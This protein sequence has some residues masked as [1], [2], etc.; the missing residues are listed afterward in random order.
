ME[1]VPTEELVRYPL[2]LDII[3]QEEMLIKQSNRITKL[4][5]PTNS[6]IHHLPETFLFNPVKSSMKTSLINSLFLLGFNA[7]LVGAQ[8]AA[9]KAL[10]GSSPVIA[11]E[12][13]VKVEAQELVEVSHHN[14][15]NNYCV[16]YGR[17]CSRDSECCAGYCRAGY[18]CDVR[19]EEEEEVQDIE[20]IEEDNV[21]EENEELKDEAPE[22]SLELINVLKDEQVMI[23]NGSS[24]TR[25]GGQCSRDSEC[26]SGMCSSVTFK[27]CFY[28]VIPSPP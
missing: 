18:S 7:S 16:S 8:N 26:C 21:Q 19:N 10:R 1:Q 11:F 22:Y 14:P 27:I 15:V 5:H 4:H 2:Y 25:Y 3:F 6:H 13:Y 28:Q 17:R 23:E 20:L 24:C 9:P 12:D